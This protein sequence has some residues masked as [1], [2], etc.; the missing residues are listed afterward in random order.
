MKQFKCRLTERALRLTGKGLKLR[1]LSEISLLPYWHDSVIFRPCYK[2]YKDSTEKV[3]FVSTEM[4]AHLY[5]KDGP[6]SLI[7]KAEFW[8]VTKYQCENIVFFLYKTW[9]VILEHKN[10]RSWN[11]IKLFTA[12]VTKST[13]HSF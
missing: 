13:A 8:L 7:V 4:S 12:N 6:V 1:V 10:W 5:H 11:T 9:L 3:V 2:S